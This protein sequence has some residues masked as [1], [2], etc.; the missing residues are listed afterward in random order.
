M[1]SKDKGI[2]SG[3]REVWGGR[4]VQK[5]TQEDRGYT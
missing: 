4:E 1:K 2:K 3:A 5:Q